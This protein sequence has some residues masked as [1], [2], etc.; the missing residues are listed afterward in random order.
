[1]KVIS[2]P[3][4]SGKTTSIKQFVSTSKE[5]CLVVVNDIKSQETFRGIATICNHEEN[6][7]SKVIL[8]KDNIVITKAKFNNIL[9]LNKKQLSLFE[10]IFIDESS[11]LNPI[12]MENLSAS[13]EH[14]VNLLHVTMS[15]KE[16][17]FS[18]HMALLT[19]IKYIKDVIL[20]SEFSMFYKYPISETTSEMAKGLLEDLLIDYNKTHDITSTQVVQLMYFISAISANELYIGERIVNNKRHIDVLYVNTSLKTFLQE[21]KSEVLVYDATA[22]ISSPLYEYLNIQIEEYPKLTYPNLKFH[23]HK[24]TYLTPSSGRKSKDNTLKVLQEIK[25]ENRN[26]ELTFCIK[27]KQELLDDFGFELTDY[28]FSGRDVGSNEYRDL[29][30]INIV[31]SNTLPIHYRCLYNKI[32]RN[33]PIEECSSPIELKKAESIIM[34]DRLSQLIGRLAIRQD[35]NAKVDV[36]FYCVDRGQIEVAK[37]HFQLPEENIILYST[38]D[39]GIPQKSVTIDDILHC[40]QNEMQ[41]A[42]SGR[43]INVAET[44]RE[45]LYHPNT[46]KNTISSW[47]KGKNRERIVELA[48]KNKCRIEAKSGRGGGFFVVFN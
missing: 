43:R 47:Y 24:Y 38:K 18:K 8:T 40:L 26:N 34:G 17:Y 27:S 4:G 35:S 19:K 21:T 9:I 37:E 2:K 23:I 28:I 5:R 10:Y 16:C 3:L 25:E 20:S 36:H 12:I 45:S 29:T 15:K 48:T 13:I 22:E 1:M 31:Y 32:I 14:L 42:W 46:S 39:I 7:F 11:G 44:I 6:K 30:S 33:I 41:F